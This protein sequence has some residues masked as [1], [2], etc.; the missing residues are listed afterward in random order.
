VSGLSA[1]KRNGKA[2]GIEIFAHI[3]R[4][5]EDAAKPSEHPKATATMGWMANLN[6]LE[7]GD[8]KNI[9]YDE[10]L[11]SLSIISQKEKQ[12]IAVEMTIGRAI[13]DN[14][15]A[16]LI[17]N[18]LR[19]S[20]SV[21]GQGRKDLKEIM[22]GVKQNISM[23]TSLQKMRRTLTGRGGKTE[24]VETTDTVEVGGE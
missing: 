24:E 9:L 3:R 18:L 2:E 12:L 15:S 21:K 19:L 22:G 8:D 5:H 23:P 10:M 1:E 7:A 14:V 13:N 20:P 16:S 6:D 17:E 4:A 11:Q